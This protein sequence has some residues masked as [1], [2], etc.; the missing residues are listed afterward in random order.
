MIVTG[1]SP[2]RARPAP[3]GRWR[4]LPRNWRWPVRQSLPRPALPIS[5]STSGR[6]Q[7]RTCCS[8]SAIQGDGGYP[9]SAPAPCRP[10]GSPP[11]GVDRPA[12]SRPHGRHA[13]NRPVTSRPAPAESVAAAS[14]HGMSPTARLVAS[15]QRSTSTG[16]DE[17]RAAVR[18]SPGPPA[19][20]AS[21]RADRALLLRLPVRPDGQSADPGHGVAKSVEAQPSV[22]DGVRR[23]R[24]APRRAS[25]RRRPR[26][27]GTT[28]RRRRSAPV[29]APSAIPYVRLMAAISSASVTTTP[30][31]PISSRRI[32]VSQRRE[33]LAARSSTAGTTRCPAITQLTPA[34]DRR[35]KGRQRNG[36]Q[37]GQVGVD[38]GHRRVRIGRRVAVPG[39]ML[40]A[41]MGA[42]RPDDRR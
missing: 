17:L 42:A 35:P 19:R 7:R 26:R 24:S 11:A 23:S 9:W 16:P 29:T 5:T 34:R 39:E 18:R 30:S 32:S 25:A 3:R 37:A 22:P 15:S 6:C 1:R 38:D 4:R 21:W 28:G 31:K 20:P 14:P 12:E 33:T 8:T 13:A 41:G 27:P 2:T 40:D 10:P 36:F